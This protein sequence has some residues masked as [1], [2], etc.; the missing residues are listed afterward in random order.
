MTESLWGEDFVVESSPIKTKKII[1]KITKPKSSK[2]QVSITDKLK[3]IYDEVY[4]IL[5]RYKENTIVIKTKE[6]LHEYID[7]AIS[8]NVIA[9]DTETNNSLQ[10]LTCKLMGPCIYTPGCKNAY[11][12]INHVNPITRE[13]L[14]WQLT[15]ADINEEFSRLV[16]VPIIMH[17]GKFDYQ[18]I[19][20]TTGVQLKVYWDTMIAA[21]ILD[22]NEKSAGLKQQ[23]IAKIDP[24]I[25]KYSIEHL[26]E[27]IE[28]A[29]VDPEVFA[30]YAATDAYMTYKL[31]MWQLDKFK[32]SE[33]KKLF[34][35]FLNVEMPIMEVAAEMEMTGIELDL[36]YSQRL[37]NKYHKLAD[38]VKAKI[39]NQLAQYKDLIDNWRKTD[40]AN[41]HPKSTKPNKDGE[42]KYQKSKN[43]QL[44]DPPQLTSNT[45]FAI[46][47]YDVLKVPVVDKENPR[48]TGEDILK[49]IDNPLCELVLEQR[50]IDKLINTYIDK[51]PKCILPETGRLHAHFNQLGADTGRFSSSDP[52]LQNIPSHEKA[53]RM[54]FKASD[55]HVLVGS[56][57]SQQEPRLLSSY[58]LDDNMIN[59]YKQNKDLYASIASGVYGVP[60]EDCLEHHPDGSNYPDGAER[61][62]SVKGLLLGIM[63][64]MSAN[65]IAETIKKPIKEA[66]K[67][68][69][70]FYSAFPKVKTWMDETKSFAKRFGYVEDFWGRRRR[71]PDITKDKYEI[72]L[73]DNNN[74]L[75]FNPLLGSK[76]IV[77][78]TI[79][80]SIIKY[81]SL[82]EKCRSRKDVENVKA[83]ALNEGVI[84][85]DNSYFISQAE[86]QCV[87]ARIQG[88]AATMSKKAMIKVY[89][90][91]TLKEL[92]FKLLLA[93]HDELIGE[94]PIENKDEVADRLTLLMKESALPE[95]VTPFKCDATI[96]N[97]WY[98]SEY[99]GKIK[100]E[101]N[102]NIESMSEEE[103]I[104][105]LL[106]IHSECTRENII[107]FIYNFS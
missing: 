71:L 55:G 44:L 60:Y 29:L 52:N 27:D 33:H 72:Y 91:N 101:H 97:V 34:D 102:A 88:G 59:S 12:P 39:D 61:R 100:K 80:S 81:Q 25:E 56:D 13:R 26:F 54:M 94:C 74:S 18:V 17:N 57:F 37:S 36:E 85:K 69:D 9:I 23:Y 86:R 66:Q 16:N 10:P 40:E 84:I 105:K 45:Q 19:K 47:L 63:Y 64:G 78:K 49:K 21:R 98:E 82:V 107:N 92:G 50:G 14:N 35:L 58:A 31:Y 73:K 28:Y 41:F 62:K 53:I 22:E 6:Q 20:C 68:I 4:R 3:S 79:P 77:K 11:I 90:D 43:E 8:N 87:N 99:A 51:L 2:T 48:G 96:E 42:Y 89:N 67:I 104:N 95:V 5:G 15:E 30:L 70:D 103:S 65:S 32:L 106:E 38:N 93:V 75:D 83:Q 24:T 46:L 76:D 7:S 1:D